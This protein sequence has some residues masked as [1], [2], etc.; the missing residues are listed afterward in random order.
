ML[1]A[2]AV[3]WL[4]YLALGLCRERGVSGVWGVE[5]REGEYMMR[6]A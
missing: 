5:G 6:Y 3:F 2:E 1:R 4:C